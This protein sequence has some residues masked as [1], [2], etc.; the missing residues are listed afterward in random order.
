MRKLVTLEIIFVAVFTPLFVHAQPANLKA[1]MLKIVEFINLFIPIIFGIT[2]LAFLWGAAQ[3]ILNKGN[4]EQISR[5]R[6]MLV[7]GIIGIFVMV[8]VW[9]FVN[10]IKST[11]F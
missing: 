7:W 4:A 1:F 10:V 2:L 5:G 11:F 3:I 9:G 6:V 8:S